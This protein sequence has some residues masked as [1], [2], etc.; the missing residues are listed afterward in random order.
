ML[1]TLL[2]IICLCTPLYA[3][4][5]VP[6][7]PSILKN[8]KRT[9]WPPAFSVVFTEPA[10]RNIVPGQLYFPGP[11][12]KILVVLVE[13]PDCKFSDLTPLNRS[14]GSICDENYYA[15]L[16]FGGNKAGS[17]KEI[18]YS[19]KYNSVN[20][21][22]REISCNQSRLIGNIM[23]VML[24]KPRNHYSEDSSIEV[25]NGNSP[26]SQ[27]LIDTAEQLQKQGI[28]ISSYDY[29]QDGYID[30][31]IVIAAASC[32]A[33]CPQ[34]DEVKDNHIWPKRLL[35]TDNALTLKNRKKLGWGIVAA[36]DSPMGVIAHELLHELGAPDLYDPDQGH[37]SII[38]DNSFPVSFWGIMDSG[39]WNYKHGQ[40]PGECPAHPIGFIKWKMGWIEPEFITAS[41]TVT[42]KAIENNKNNC[43]YRISTGKGDY[44]LL[45]NRFA[46]LKNTYYDKAFAGDAIPMDSGLIISHI[47]ENMIADYNNDYTANWGTPDYAHYAVRI[48]DRSPFFKEVYDERKIDAAFS[49]E[50]FQAELTPFTSYANSSSYFSKGINISIINISKSGS[51]MN[52]TISIKK[53]K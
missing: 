14:Y 11:K 26:L 47:D 46:L 50:D 2:I 25:D 45:E 21:Y 6:P 39:A 48:L 35:F 10:G 49:M 53:K 52:A 34:S 18:K 33:S 5:A 15:R 27:I 19:S 38:D 17:G 23:Q 24:D 40:S 32:Q 41:K 31:L 37:Y 44:F 8:V 42:I 16:I 28:D 3:I 43:L 7:S 36:F 30:H 29:D 20:K 13:F 51:T 12:E 1:K 4:Y 9:G 22:T